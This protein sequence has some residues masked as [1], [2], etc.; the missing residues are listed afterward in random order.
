MSVIGDFLRSVGRFGTQ[1]GNEIFGGMPD[2]ISKNKNR[3]SKEAA[4][5]PKP[6]TKEEEERLDQMLAAVRTEIP[7]DFRAQYNPP[8][9]PKAAPPMAAAP[10]ARPPMGALDAPIPEDFR[11]PYNPPPMPSMT[12]MPSLSPQTAAE[13]AQ[14]EGPLMAG[15][16]GLSQFLGFVPEGGIKN[17]GVTS[18]ANVARALFRQPTIQ[19]EEARYN[20]SIEPERL[21]K[22]IAAGDLEEI[23]K[24]DPAQAEQIRKYRQTELDTLQTKKQDLARAAMAVQRET[25]MPYGE[26]A[27]FVNERMGG[28]SFTEEELAIADQGGYAG[29]ASALGREDPYRDRLIL[30]GGNLVFDAFNMTKDSLGQYDPRFREDIDKRLAE[31]DLLESQGQFTAERA[32]YERD[33]VAADARRAEAAMINAEANRMRAIKYQPG[34]GADTA[35]AGMFTAQ[36]ADQIT[37]MEDLVDLGVAAGSFPTTDKSYL[38]NVLTRF[39][40]IADEASG[41]LLLAGTDRQQITEQLSS[42]AWSTV[43]TVRG[44]LT[45]R[46]VNV[47]ATQLNTEKE[48]E[49]FV[50]TIADPKANAETIKAGLRRLRRAYLQDLQMYGGGEAGAGQGTAEQDRRLREGQIVRDPQGKPFMVRDGALVEMSE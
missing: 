24:I 31:I 36:L 35:A 1:A 16:R 47:G 9:M 49:R 17:D 46:G 44:V 4:P 20:Q 41:G 28:N 29:L 14:R 30:G 6:R 34:G 21:R 15:A 40:N 37:E 12:P 11:A 27:R 3:S 33:R 5:A 13:P 42:A 39:G 7:A 48:A 26:A 10:S 18:V 45:S 38:E 22:A 43:N 25:D 32:Q 19:Q 23:A 2:Y 8:V 50:K